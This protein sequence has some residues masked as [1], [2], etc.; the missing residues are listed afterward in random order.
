MKVKIFNE[1]YSDWLESKMNEWLLEHQNYSIM[2]I[3][4]ST[5]PRNGCVYYTA[6]VVYKDKS[7]VV[8]GVNYGQ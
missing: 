7:D 4:Y 2:N 3:Q 6:M 5:V 1:E 8:E